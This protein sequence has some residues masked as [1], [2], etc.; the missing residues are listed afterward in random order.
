MVVGDNTEQRL[1]RKYMK[2]NKGAIM[3][4]D[5]RLDFEEVEVLDFGWWRY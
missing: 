3:G 2:T 4:K 1:S 5:G